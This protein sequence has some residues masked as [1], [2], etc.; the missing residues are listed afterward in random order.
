MLDREDLTPEETANSVA[1][2]RREIATLWQTEEQRD[3]T[4]TPLDEVRG[5]LAVFQQ[6]LWDALP[7]YVRQVDRALIEPLPLDAAPLRFGSWIGG[8]RDG[9]PNV[10]PETTRRAIWMAR[11]VAADLYLRE[12]MRSAPSSR[13]R[14]PARS[15]GERPATRTSPT[16]RCCARSRRDCGRRA[17]SRRPASNAR[18]GGESLATRA[19][20]EVADFLAP[21][22]L[23]HRSLIATGNAGHRQRPAHRHLP[24]DRRVRSRPRAARPAA[25]INETRR[26]DRVA[27][28]GM[29][30]G[31]VQDGGRGRHGS[32]G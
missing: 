11:W 21:L 32:R 12:S 9:N 22:R 1:S 13:S 18:S 26:R 7:R 5:G 17:R 20:L 29:A 3:R 4:V 2:L 30:T 19:Y 10:T 31:P 16:A 15:F 28:T 8:D 23:C 24:P 6:T 14:R 25:G 27:R